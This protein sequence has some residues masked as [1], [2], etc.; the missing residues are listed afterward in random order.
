MAIAK[1]VVLQVRE[2]EATMEWLAHHHHV[3]PLSAR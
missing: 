1:G 3:L 2:T